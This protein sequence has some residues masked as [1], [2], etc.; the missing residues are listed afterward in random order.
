MF[1]D[2]YPRFL[3]TSS[4]AS[5]KK[6]LRMRH[7]AIFGSHAE[8]FPGARVLD[9]ASH[10]ARWSM[11]ALHAGAAH[12]TGI[13]ANRDLLKAAEETFQ[14]YDVAPDTYRFINDDVFDVLGDPLAHEL[15]VDLVMCIGFIYH[16]LRYQDLFAGVR[17]LNPRYFLVDT[18]VILAEQPMVKLFSED[19]SKE[20]SGLDHTFTRE[21]RLI[22]GRPSIPA[23]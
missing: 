3:D 19:V 15:D 4:T 13:E 8:I 16:T 14:H 17:A 23:L 12:T 20:S 6:R 1:F 22:T 18:A 21:G 5:N 7:H 11:A 9:I 10:D 2:E